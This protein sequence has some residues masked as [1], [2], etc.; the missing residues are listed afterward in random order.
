MLFLIQTFHPMHGYES[1]DSA[2][3]DEA[4]GAMLAALTLLKDFGV[5]GT[6]VRITNQETDHVL[7]EGK[8]PLMGR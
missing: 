1:I 8:R 7:Y 2:E 4:E 3:S 6:R 5:M